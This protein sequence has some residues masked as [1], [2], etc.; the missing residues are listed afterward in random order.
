[1]LLCCVSSCGTCFV[2]D[3]FV[4]SRK[5][6]GIKAYNKKSKRIS[7][8]TL[9]RL[10]RRSGDVV[11]EME[12]ASELRM[13]LAVEVSPVLTEALTLARSAWAFSVVRT[14]GW[15]EIVVVVRVEA[16]SES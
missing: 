7:T 12:L 9:K 5:K 10:S 13:A 4:L 11:L 6:W 3:I 1:M 2:V 15:S 16:P 14:W 8:K